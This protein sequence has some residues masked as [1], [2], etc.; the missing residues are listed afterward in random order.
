MSILM[1]VGMGRVEVLPRASGDLETWLWQDIEGARFGMERVDGVMLSLARTSVTDGL[2]AEA[3][4]ALPAYERD[5][6]PPSA[7]LLGQWMQLLAVVRNPPEPK[8]MRAMAALFAVALSDF[9]AGAF[10]PATQRRAATTFKFWPS[11]A[12]VAELVRP[13]ADAIRRGVTVL[14]YLE[15]IRT[16][17]A[18][19]ARPLA[20][21][22][23]RALP[24]SSPQARPVARG[25]H[26]NHP[27]GGVP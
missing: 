11:A 2:L 25:G 18:Q 3:S 10:T 20:Q 4:R 23:Q 22:S 19:G 1:S 7:D 21:H 6:L 15:S 13:E 5:A 14:R 17:R 26:A 27:G 8:A 12:D 9:P 24:P 16:G